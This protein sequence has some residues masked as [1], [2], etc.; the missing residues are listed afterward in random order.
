M[1]LSCFKRHCENVGKAIACIRTIV[2]LTYMY[3]AQAVA[4]QASAARA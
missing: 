2:Y 1:M 4:A 3:D